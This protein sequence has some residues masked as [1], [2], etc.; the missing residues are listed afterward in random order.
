MP[1]EMEVVR[2]FWGLGRRLTVQIMKRR[3]RKKHTDFSSKIIVR[4]NGK[5]DAQ[6]Q[7][8]NIGMMMRYLL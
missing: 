1:A 8:Q 6:Y 2:T 4:Q 7:Q 5:I 3:R